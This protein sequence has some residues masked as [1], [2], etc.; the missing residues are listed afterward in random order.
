LNAPDPSFTQQYI[1][2]TR[3][4]TNLQKRAADVN[5]SGSIQS[6]DVTMMKRRILGQTYTSWI[7][8]TEYVWDGPFIPGWHGASPSWTPIVGLQV[9]VAGSEVNV[10]LKTL[11]TGDVNS[12]FTPLPNP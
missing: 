10:E 6:I 5:L 12:S 11:C 1:L 2:G 9:I 4:L 3:V 8:P 7:R